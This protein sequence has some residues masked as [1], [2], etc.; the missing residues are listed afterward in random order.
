MAEQLSEQQQRES[1]EMKTSEIIEKNTDETV[2]DAEAE[3]SDANDGLIITTEQ[4]EEEN[5]EKENQNHQELLL[6]QDITEDA[7]K[8]IDDEDEIGSPKEGND[9]KFVL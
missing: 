9:D 1:M 3:E 4:E 7:N 2:D 5:S 6:L 8:K